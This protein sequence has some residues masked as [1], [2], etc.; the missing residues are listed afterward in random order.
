M[1]KNNNQTNG[2][3]T[4]NA[5]LLDRFRHLDDET[6]R[7]AIEQIATAVGVNERQAERAAS[8]VHRI[9][10]QLSGMN[11]RD[12]QTLAARIKPETTQEIVRTLRTEGLL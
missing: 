9:R 4:I 2:D 6:L 7:R 3:F 12:L 11:E 8:N 10:Q 1:D 5:E